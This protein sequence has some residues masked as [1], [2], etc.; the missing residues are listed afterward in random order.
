MNSIN[1]KELEEEQLDNFFAYLTIH[2][3]ENGKGGIVFQPVSKEQ[4]NLNEEWKEKFSTGLSK[5]YKEQGGRTLWI[6]TNQQGQIVGHIDIRARPEPNTGH[7]V[8]LGMGV[9]SKF[10]NLRI[11]QQL[12]EFVIDYCRK[13]PMI[14]WLDLEVMANNIPAIRLYEKKKFQTLS[15]TVDMFRIENVSYDYTSMTLNVDF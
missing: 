14:S 9:D 3:A 8:L 10:R 1:I 15:N 13:E 5:K 11:G 2:L 7:R 6:A 4:S 12:L